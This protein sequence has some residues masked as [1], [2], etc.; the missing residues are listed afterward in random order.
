[1]FYLPPR[2]L[3]PLCSDEATQP[4]YAGWV[5]PINTA[6][7]PYY[8]SSYAAIVAYSEETICCLC[9]GAS[10]PSG[11][12]AAEGM[13]AMRP[14]PLRGKAPAA[15]ASIRNMRPNTKG[16]GGG[17]ALKYEGAP[18]R[19]AAATHCPEGAPGASKRTQSRVSGVTRLQ[20]VPLVRKGYSSRR[21]LYIMTA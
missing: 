12:V 5:G 4:S 16:V 3:R 7:R 20:I 1:M 13:A 11:V 14:R 6:L 2:G 15:R 18:S 19:S 21:L 10:A 9:T 17:V 8:Y